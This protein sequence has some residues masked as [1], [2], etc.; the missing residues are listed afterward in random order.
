MQ[1]DWDRLRVFHEVA[2]QGS[3]IGA[4]DL[5]HLTGPAVS[6]QVRTLEREI[7]ATLI[8][9]DGRGIRLTGAGHVLASHAKSIHASVMSATKEVA[10]LARDVA[11]PLRIGSVNATMREVVPTT[12][13][14]LQAA[15][16]RLQIEAQDGEASTLMPLL[17]AGDVDIVLAESWSNR[18][19]STP[20]GVTVHP[21]L[22]EE[23][24]LALPASVP[25]AIKAT[26][27]PSG[28]S[29]AA[30]A[31]PPLSPP[32]LSPSRMSLA[33]VPQHPW[34]A[35]PVG[36]E[37]HDGMVQALRERGVEPRIA[38]MA[39]DFATQ[40]EIVREG[41][42]YALVP[43]IAQRWSTGGVVFVPIVRPIVRAI[44]VLTRSG[45]LGPAEQACLEMLDV[46]AG[47]RLSDDD[48]S[49]A[50]SSPG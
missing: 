11:G 17:R 34:I 4:A 26:A 40:L 35:C 42:A 21:L 3:I 32:P 47:E 33:R 31:P 30:S 36:A 29:A 49:A 45:E 10:G 13:G 44:V 15:H 37:A 27:P 39:A 7:E 9:P 20:P 23:V 18:R 5:L 1:L 22:E 25:A 16:P 50:V 19:L 41:L 24:D 48:A 46:V 43:R 28:V 14:R 12:V 6:R 8:E 2:E 38:F